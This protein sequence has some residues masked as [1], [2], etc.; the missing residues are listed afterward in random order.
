MM[1]ELTALRSHS[2]AMACEVAKLRSST[3]WRIT[4]P[5]RSSKRLLAPPLGNGPFGL[6]LVVGWRILRTGSML[7]LRD[8]QAVRTIARSRLFDR[9]WLLARN[10]DVAAAGADPV[11]HY[12]MFGAHEG[13]EPPASFESSN[14][15]AA[16]L[17][18]AAAE[19]IPCVVSAPHDSCS[20]LHEACAERAG[21]DD[22]APAETAS[23]PQGV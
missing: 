19:E 3:S 7:P 2:D 17:D 9:A 15:H 22:S 1:E 12:V 10:P 21:W 23:T 20:V 8:L 6:P 4:A 11:M 14:N 18:D 13:R 16:D 5:L